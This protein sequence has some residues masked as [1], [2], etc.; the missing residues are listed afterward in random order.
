M[1]KISITSITTWALVSRH[2]QIVA[3]DTSKVKSIA[4][5][6][7]LFPL[8]GSVLTRWPKS[9][10]RRVRAAREQIKRGVGCPICSGHQVLIGFNDLATTHPELIKEADGWNPATITKGHDKKLNWKCHLGQQRY[11]EC[12]RPRVQT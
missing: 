11:F 12:S 5:E 2:F 4:K 10:S 6:L 1:S 9:D 7:Q 3:K 8:C